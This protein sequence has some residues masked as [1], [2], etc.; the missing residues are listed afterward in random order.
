MGKSGMFVSKKMSFIKS[1][2]HCTLSDIPSRYSMALPNHCGHDVLSRSANPVVKT[3]VDEFWLVESDT[4]LA[5]SPESVW[6]LD[7]I[8]ADV[9][10]GAS[11]VVSV[12][13]L[14]SVVVR[15]DRI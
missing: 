6:D 5:N 3:L 15:T 10:V 9:L 8:S 1:A 13:G 11:L 2:F 7:V 12:V 4:L 14:V